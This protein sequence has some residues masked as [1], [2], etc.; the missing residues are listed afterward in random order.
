MAVCVCANT[1]SYIQTYKSIPHAGNS[2]TKKKIIEYTDE[3][4]FSLLCGGK[5]YLVYNCSPTKDNPGM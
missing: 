1:Q 3:E 5:S 2:C 4:Q